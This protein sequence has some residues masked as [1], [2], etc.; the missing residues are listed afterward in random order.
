MSHSKE[1]SLENIQHCTCQLLLVKKKKKK[2]TVVIRLL[3]KVYANA[4]M[5]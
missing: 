4:D 1:K 3:L 5:F 2:K